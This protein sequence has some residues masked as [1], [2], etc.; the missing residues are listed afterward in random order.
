MPTNRLRIFLH[1]ILNKYRISSSARLE[2]GVVLAVNAATIGCASIAAGNVFDGP[3]SLVIEDGV[4]LGNKNT[5]WSVMGGEVAN[6]EEPEGGAPSM[7][8]CIIRRNVLIT[9][10]HFF[11]STGGFEVGEGTWIAGRGSQVWTHGLK[12]GPVMIGNNCYVGTHVIM[13]PRSA[14]GSFNVI[15]PGSVVSQRFNTNNAT[16]GGVPARI[17]DSR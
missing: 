17:T 11:D 6:M 10:G 13:S 7:Y 2:F 16:L 1:R 15:L 3:F 5:F 14:T 8:S 12:S 9:E 4:V